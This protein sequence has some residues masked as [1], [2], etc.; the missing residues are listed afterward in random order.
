MHASFFSV[1]DSVAFLNRLEVVPKTEEADR[2]L[3]DTATL[4]EVQLTNNLSQVDLLPHTRT[5][6]GKALRHMAWGC[7]T[8][9]RSGPTHAAFV[10]HQGAASEAE[11]STMIK[12]PTAQRSPEC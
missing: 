9:R 8:I 4:P 3:P 12:L 6:S 7:G 1:L 10:D 11:I 5:W 2:G